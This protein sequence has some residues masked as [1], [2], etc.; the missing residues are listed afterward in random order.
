MG[1]GPGMSVPHQT[2][3]RRSEETMQEDDRPAGTDFAV[4]KR[5]PIPALE[6]PDR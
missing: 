1:K 3:G 5:R 2:G 4:G 6:M